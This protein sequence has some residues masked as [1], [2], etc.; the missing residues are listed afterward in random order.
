MRRLAVHLAVLAVV[1]FVIAPAATSKQY[2]PS[3]AQLRCAMA[4]TRQDKARKPKHFST[5]LPTA[6]SSILG[7]L[8]SGEAVQLPSNA[9]KGAQ[10]YLFTGLW[11]NSVRLLAAESRT[12]VY[13]IPGVL[14]PPPLPRACRTLLS[15]H[16]VALD[17]ELRRRRQGPGVILDFYTPR[18]NVVSTNREISITGIGVPF[19]VGQIEAGEAHI[20]FPRLFGGE[21]PMYG[22]V[23]DGVAS[24]VVTL[25]GRSASGSVQNNLF[26]AH[27]PRAK[28]SK[29]TIV[30]RWYS[31]TGTLVK[32]ITETYVVLEIRGEIPISSNR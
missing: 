14:S 4:Q 17:E 12:S 22:L 5:P 15:R 16:Q 3:K 27:I 7:V 32:T 18:E 6:L 11:L 28:K 24:V 20:I 23:P 1:L 9:L 10:P 30:Q 2:L 26:I 29:N 19:T 8:R 25:D 13:L 21:E 31:P